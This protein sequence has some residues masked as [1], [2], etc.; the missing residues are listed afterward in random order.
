[1]SGSHAHNRLSPG[2]FRETFPARHLLVERPLPTLTFTDT[3]L[4]PGSTHG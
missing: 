1:M 4:A 3:G 2:G